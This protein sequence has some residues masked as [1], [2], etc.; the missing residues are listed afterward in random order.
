V[1]PSLRPYQGECWYRSASFY[2]ALCRRARAASRKSSVTRVREEG[3]A[4]SD[5]RVDGQ[6]LNA[7]NQERLARG[8]PP[9]EAEVVFL[10]QHIFNSRVKRDSYSIDDVID[11][12]ASAMDAASVARETFRGTT[13]E[14]LGKREDQYG[15]RVRDL[16]VLECSAR[17]P[18]PELF[19]II[20]KGD[21]NKPK[22]KAAHSS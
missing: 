16:A 6:Q 13:L 3:A 19:S 18:R 7:I 14:S 9:I 5:W 4:C 22:K 17:H 20:P 2:A 15:N 11:Q 21:V 12:I 10:G 1:A 8:Y